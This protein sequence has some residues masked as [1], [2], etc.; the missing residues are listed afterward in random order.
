MTATANQFGQWVTGSRATS[1]NANASTSNNSTMQNYDARV[2]KGW[3][4]PESWTGM[5]GPVVNFSEPE[6]GEIVSITDTPSVLAV[7]NDTVPESVA[8]SDTVTR[9]VIFVGSVAESMA[10]S[11]SESVLAVFAASIAETLGIVD[12]SDAIVVTPGISASVSETVS[13]FD[14]VNSPSI[15]FVSVDESV[16]IGEVIYADVPIP[17]VPSLAPPAVRDP[18]D[19][20]EWGHFTPGSGYHR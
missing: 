20:D 12:T 14:T 8:I 17:V 16:L 9:T 2:Q 10:I 15:F 5:L 3:S 13:I 11:D 6:V 19:I 1:F 4:A 7:L 18:W